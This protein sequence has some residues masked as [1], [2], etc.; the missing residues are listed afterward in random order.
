ML[1]ILDDNGGADVTAVYRSSK[2]FSGYPCAHRRWKHDGHCAFV[3]GYSRSFTV[4]FESHERTDNGFVVDFGMF[5]DVRSW[6]KT[7][8]DHTLLIDNDDPLRPEFEA[9][10]EAGACRLVTY[11]DVGMEGTARFVYAWLQPWIHAQTQ[12][13]AWVVSVE[14]AENEKNSAVFIPSASPVKDCSP[15]N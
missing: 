10:H 14:V 9:L 15:S 13:R 2:R 7:H 11:D 6:L 3:H 4:W 1:C 8:F 12:G 5:A